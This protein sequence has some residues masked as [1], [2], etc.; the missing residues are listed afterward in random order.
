MAKNAPRSSTRTAQIY[1]HVHLFFFNEEDALRFVH[2]LDEIRSV[3][4]PR[5]PDLEATADTS[6]VTRE[7]IVAHMVAESHCAVDISGVTQEL[8]VAHMEAESQR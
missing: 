6:E 7:L 1:L 8:N 4:N 5:R 3:D 2:A